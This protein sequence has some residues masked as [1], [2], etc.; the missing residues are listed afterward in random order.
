MTVSHQAENNNKETGIIKKSHTE[1][2]ELNGTVTEMKNSPVGLNRICE[3]A[4]ERVSELENRLIE[5]LKAEE[6]RENRIM[7][8]GQ[9][10]R[11]HWDTFNCSTIHVRG[12]P[13]GEEKE[14]GPEQRVKEIRPHNFSNW[15]KNIH[16]HG[17]CLHLLRST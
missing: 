1:I 16:K 4:E 5:I 13:H 6:Q 12:V 17:M 10:L 9:S 15:L 8:S 14:K 11:E 7:R 2:L 3:L